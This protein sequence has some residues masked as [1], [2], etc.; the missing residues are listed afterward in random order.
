[1][2]SNRNEEIARQAEA[3][4]NSY[5][6]KTGAFHGAQVVTGDDLSTNASYNKR[7]PPS[8]GGEIDDRG[9][10]TRGS[11]F[12]GEGGPVEQIEQS[13]INQPGQNDSDVVAGSVPIKDHSGLPGTAAEGI[14]ASIHN[15]GRNSPGPGG[16]QYKGADY[17]TPEDVPDSI[18]AERN[19]P[20]SSI[21]QASRETEGYGAGERS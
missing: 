18:A 19:I 9:R 14:E 20:P 1:M 8:E 4:L 12:E 3:D 21:T 2:S 17:R 10:Q 13:Y 6:T 7:I 5:Q 11:H 15:V 16:S